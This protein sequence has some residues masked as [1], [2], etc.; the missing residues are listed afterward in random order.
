ML[1]YMFILVSSLLKRVRDE[2]KEGLLERRFHL[3]QALRNV[4]HRLFIYLSILL[5]DIVSLFS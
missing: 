5:Y 2:M 3:V 4:S 1:T